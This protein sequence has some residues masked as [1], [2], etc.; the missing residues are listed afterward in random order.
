MD[1]SIFKNEI[2]YWENYFSNSKKPEDR[3]FELAFFKIFVKFELF[4][5]EIFV[6]YSIGNQ[7]VNLYSPIRKLNFTDKNHFDCVIKNKNSNYIDYFSKMYDLA[8]YVFEE[9]NS[10]FI[11]FNDPTCLQNINQMRILRNYIAHESNS[12]KTEYSKQ[13]LNGKFKEPYEFLLKIKK[14]KTISNYTYYTN[15]LIE[16]SNYL[17]GPYPT[18]I[19]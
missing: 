2:D 8:P 16:I 7:S 15:S 5:S 13:L 10:P 18:I 1:N 12:S 6:H 19:D 4:V 14:G 17:L 3:L 9:E 11:I